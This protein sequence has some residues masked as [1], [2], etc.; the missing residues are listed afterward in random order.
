MGR[1]LDVRGVRRS[2][3]TD[4]RSLTA[5]ISL[6]RRLLIE[7]GSLRIRRPV[8]FERIRTLAEEVFS[9]AF[10]G[11]PTRPFDLSLHGRYHQ[12]VLSVKA[13]RMA[14]IG[15][16]KEASRDKKKAPVSWGFPFF[17]VSHVVFP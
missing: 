10:V 6:L 17:D 9:S 3:L 1:D 4:F 5:R 7:P 13:C 12:E 15:F 2:V 11:R 8:I 16:E 14:E